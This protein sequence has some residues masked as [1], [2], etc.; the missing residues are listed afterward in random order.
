MALELAPDVAERRSRVVQPAKAE[1]A[2]VL[3][4]AALPPATSEPAAA[5]A[6]NVIGDPAAQPDVASRA[7]MSKG[8]QRQVG[9]AR[10]GALGSAPAAAPQR[11]APPAPPAA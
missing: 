11:S 7:K 1:P 8:L 6:A 2:P 4:P 3:F 10:T 5:K 9:N